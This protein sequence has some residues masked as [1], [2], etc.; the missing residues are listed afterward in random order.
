MKIEVLIGQYIV[1]VHLYIIWDVVMT[2]KSKE[3]VLHACMS[4]TNC[5][6]LIA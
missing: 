2:V 4:T 3:F 1:A 6:F 5:V